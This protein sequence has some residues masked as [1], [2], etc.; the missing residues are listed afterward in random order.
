MADPSDET[1]R[2]D[3]PLRIGG[4]LPEP[5]RVGGLPPYP[6]IA[7]GEARCRAGDPVPGPAP[8]VAQEP[9]PRVGGPG[10][11]LVLGCAVVGA[12]ATL[13]VASWPIWTA[14]PRPEEGPPAAAPATGLDQA[15]VPEPVSGQPTVSF[16]P[17]PVSLSTRASVRSPR[18]TASPTDRPRKPAGG[19]T[20]RP[21]PSTT[22]PG[23]PRSDELPPLPPSREPSL[24]SSGGGAE[25]FVDFVNRRD[26][27]VVV[28][29][30]DYDGQRRRYAVLEPGRS[31]RQQTYL[32]HPWVVT[33][34][35]GHGLVCFLPAPDVSRA[36]I[37]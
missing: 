4:W 23:Q 31:Y 1:H 28:H 17:A 9:S 13:A 19:T 2:P 34:A 24:R 5:R 10:R 12:L 33:D 29:W 37:R 14:P 25:T 6:S 7:P 27:E 15:A 32:G 22:P 21:R 35:G 11:A 8:P 20:T 18:P 36:V 30:L 26:S 3:A 16:S